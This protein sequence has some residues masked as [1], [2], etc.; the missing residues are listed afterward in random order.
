MKSIFSLLLCI[1]LYTPTFAA[2]WYVATNGN[3]NNPGTLALPFQTLTAAIEAASPGDDILLRGGNY[4]SQEIRINKSD[5]HIASYPG[6]WAIITAVTNIED[7][8]ACLWYNEP[9]TTGGSLERLEIVGG[10]Y[11]AI[12]FE[13]NWDWDNSVPFNQRRGVSGVTIRNCNIHHSGRDAVKLTPA[14]SNISILNCEIHHTGVGPGAQLDY[15]AEGIDNVNAPNLTVRGCYFHDIATTGVY[16]KGGGRNCVIEQNR[17]ENCG[18]GGIYLGFYTD[19]EWFD[20]DFNPQYFENINGRVQNNIIVNTQ[21]AGIGLWGAKDAQVYNNTV[22]NGGQAEHAGLFFNTTDVW[23]DDTHSARVGSQNVRVENNIFVQAA[24]QNLVMV[25]V[26]ENALTGAGNT[27]NYNVYYDPNGVQ[28]LDDN[29]DWQEWTLAQWSTQTARDIHSKEANPNL[30]SSQ[31]LSATSP[32]INAGINL[33]AVTH[34]IDGHLRSDGA[35]DIGADEYG[36]VSGV[37]GLYQNT[38]FSVQLQGNVVQEQLVFEVSA[39]K[40]QDVLFQIIN[41][42]G[43]SPIEQVLSLTQGKSQQRID[44]NML[45]SGVYW[46]RAG[47]VAQAFM[48]L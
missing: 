13:T 40:N 38:N 28:F 34:D 32:C 25:R 12:K 4:T 6:E 48:K 19:A 27:I 10:Y 26:R 42:Q 37:S 20:T 7:V 39:V 14:C 15:N 46:L 29:L 24:N 17:I 21:H 18:E 43:K 41:A 33:P 44:V 9:E 45:N 1:A 35:N 16:V 23:I 31:Y 36:S 11:Y 3:D 8:S 5:L 30:N 2:T 47:N 22:V